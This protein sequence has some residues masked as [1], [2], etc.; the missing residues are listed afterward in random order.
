MGKILRLLFWLGLA[1]FGIFVVAVV[2]ILV[3]LNNADYK[4]LLIEQAQSLLGRKVEVGDVH[5]ELF[6]HVRMALDD[7]VIREADGQTPFLT[8]KRLFVD[9][10]IFPLLHRKVLVKRF[11][12]D[13]P[14]VVIKRGADGKL[15]ISDF[16]AIDRGGEAVLPMLSGETTITEGQIVFQDAFNTETIRSLSLQRVTTT[17]MASG[18]ELDFRLS[19][20]VPFQ[21]VEATVTV[22]GHVVRQP[23]SDAGPAGTAEGWVEAKGIN[24]TQ[25]APYVKASELLAGLRGV[26]DLEGMYA[27]RWAQADR[28]LT[29]TALK[30]G[31]AGTTIT[32]SAELTGL[33]SPDLQYGFKL[34][35]TPFPMEGLIGSVPEEMLRANGLGF[36][37]DG[38]LAGKIRL[39]SVRFN[40]GPGA[41]PPFSL[42]GDLEITN[43]SAVVGKDRVAVSGVTGLL[44]AEADRIAIERL[45]GRYGLAEVTEGRGE[46]TG[47]TKNP[48]LYLAIK[49][50]VTA[51]EL[52]VI[53]AR[54]APKAVLPAGPLGLKDLQGYATTMVLLNGPLARPEDL[55]VEWAI[56]AHGV[57]FLDPRL[58]LPVSDLQGGVR[59]ISRGVAFK[60][61]KGEVGYST[62][63]LDGDIAVHN[64]ERTYYDL[65]LS[66]E[67]DAEE[68]VDVATD[69]S[70][71]DLEVEGTAD[72]RLSLSGRTEELRGKG[73][74]DL[75]KTGLAHPPS[76][77]GKPVGVAGTLE[78]DLLVRPGDRLKLDQVVLDV[79][80]LKIL[81]KGTVF[82]QPPQRFSLDVRVPTV[83]IP[84]LPKGVLALKTPPDTGTFQAAFTAAGLLDNWRAATLKGR[85]GV[86]QA[87]FKLE[88]LEN[89][90]ED[91]SLD[92]SFEGDRIELER[93]SVKI[94]A[95]RITAKGTVRGWRGVPLIELALDSPG[96]D[97]QLLIPE[98]ERSPV[99]TAMEWI[100]RDSKLSARATVRNAVYHGIR[101]DEIR[102]KAT[103]ADGVIVLDPVNGKASGGT[104]SGQL[105]IALPRDKPAAVESSLHVAGV[106]VEP[107]IRGFGIKEPPFT[108]SL[109]LDGAIRGDGSH[110]RGTASTLQGDV[111][112]AIKQGYFRKLSATSKIIGIL[113][114]PTLLAGKVDFSAKGMPFDC[115]SGEMNV[116]DGI[117]EIQNYLVDSPI[118]KITGAGTYDIPDDQTDMVMAA[119]PFGSY[120]EFLES[121]PLFGRLFI[122]DREG[123]VTAFFEVKG[124]LGDP[125]VTSLPMKSVT[126]G[127]TGFAQ[128]AFD[129]LKNAILLPKELISPTKKAPSPCSA[130]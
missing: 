4:P 60:N 112:V 103:G 66:G 77:L 84:A 10:R 74:L 125:T 30:V 94:K 117:A 25:L 42:Q 76:G 122:G 116:K 120:Q 106:A 34:T 44:R 54:F 101:F 15:N 95:S 127:V 31:A 3:Y 33:F 124:P 63:A 68:L 69:G 119:S 21:K 92:A 53:V 18:R 5:V 8:A 1:L 114:L 49:G 86:K 115:V 37:R 96:L 43:G 38:Q 45:T 71:E 51:Q 102:A 121:I 98:G 23:T 90:V 70:T 118:M 40:G 56:E 47:L 73:R 80:P 36:L 19:A 108:G 85:A 16:F 111:R 105:R 81:T 104:V 83:P 62:L 39:A 11:L 9:L 107:L 123:I 41:S 110:P 35:T 24:L 128:L 113:N 7:V 126:S 93:G 6:P 52:A 46:V 50:L 59:S 130:P 22:Q 78:F 64:D 88:G 29:M 91:L 2:S 109:Y 65:T 27:Y 89:R 57:G 12:L 97:L 17:I 61:L 48:D 100:A 67:T 75:R 28:A 82:L 20:A 13:H 55:K 32:G 129:V 72:F 58:K 14:W 79:P 26:V 99:R 87:G